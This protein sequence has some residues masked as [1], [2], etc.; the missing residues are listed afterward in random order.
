M[1]ISIYEG[2]LLCSDCPLHLLTALCMRTRR[3]R[4][5]NN[6]NNTV[7][8]IAWPWILERWTISWQRNF[9]KIQV[10]FLSL[11]RLI[12]KE[13]RNQITRC[14]AVARRS[15]S[16]R[17][18]FSCTFSV[19]FCAGRLQLVCDEEHAST[20]WFSKQ[21]STIHAT[22]ASR[23]SRENVFGDTWEL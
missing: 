4:S 15:V 21:W 3:R 10:L 1:A 11:F 23:D 9:N 2:S 12:G 19:C 14:A 8:R 7:Q 16:F 17:F 6:L 18:H 5:A 20:R 22:G 13:F